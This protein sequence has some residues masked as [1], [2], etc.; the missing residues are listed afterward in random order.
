MQPETSSINNGRMAYAAHI[1]PYIAWVAIMIGLDVPAIKPAWRYAIQTICCTL[2]LL[3]LR[4]WRW[5]ASPRLRQLPLALM[6]GLLV[7]VIWVVP[8]TPWMQA[9]CPTFHNFYMHYLAV[10]PWTGAPPLPKVWPYA[11]GN[12]GWPLVVLKMFGTSVTIAVCEELFWR[13]FIYRWMLGAKFWQV[14]LGQ[15]HPFVFL[16]VN[17]VFGFEHAQWFAGIIAGLAFGWVLLRTRDIWA[18]IVTHGLTNCLL[19]IYVLV[20]GDYHFW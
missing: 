8:E 15:F 4:P 10:Q 13:S 6:M 5:Y 20:T 14:D 11:P 2:L 12:C 7:F 1:V 17:I 19:G 9:H 18:A 16:T 3:W